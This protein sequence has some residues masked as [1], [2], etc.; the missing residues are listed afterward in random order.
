MNWVQ[1]KRA[2]SVGR[3][4]LRG[5]LAMFCLTLLGCEQESP[6]EW[7]KLPLELKVEI[8]RTPEQR[9]RGL[10]FRQNVPRDEGMVFVFE[11][12]E[13]LS[14]YMR[15]TRVSLSI[16]FI[17]SDGI[18]ESVAD[19]IPLD[20]RPVASVGPAKFALEVNR[21]WFDDNG[22]RPGDMVVLE[23]NRVFFQRRVD[24]PIGER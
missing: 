16:A 7:R 17:R 19:M 3:K 23:G 4:A 15:D 5:A 9:R 1:R 11:K 24:V 21:G 8:A 12:Q 2:V 22:V 14:F 6:P 10:K 18:I 20:E 13:Q